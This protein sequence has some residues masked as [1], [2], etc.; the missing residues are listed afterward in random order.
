M[1]GVKQNYEITCFVLK[2]DLTQFNDPKRFN[3]HMK[4]L[5][6]LFCKN[7]IKHW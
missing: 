1:L 3:D 5:A 7:V 2:V 4:L 6:L